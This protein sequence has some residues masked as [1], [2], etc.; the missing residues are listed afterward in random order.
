MGQDFC[1]ERQVAV[2]SDSSVSLIS[3]TLFRCGTD[4]AFIQPSS[5]LREGQV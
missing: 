1:F 4:E 2:L 3:T 5:S